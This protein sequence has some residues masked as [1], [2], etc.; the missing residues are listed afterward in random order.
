LRHRLAH[1]V[2][3]WSLAGCTALGTSSEGSNGGRHPWTRPHVLRVGSQTSPT[4]LNPLL[5]G[6]TTESAIGRLMFDVLV[7]ID[8]SGKREVPELAQTV[9]TLENGGI[10]RDG[11]TLTYHLRKGVR[12]QDGVPLTS[13]DVKFSWG[14][15]LNPR[16]NV[17]EQ[18]GYSLVKSVDTPDDTTVVFHMKQP[19]APAVDT[20]FAESDSPYA[21]VPAHILAKYPDINSIPFNSA[22]VGS[23]PY[24]FK[25]WVR[26]DH[27]TLVRNDDYFLGK[28]KLDEIVVKFVPDENTELNELRTHDIDWQFEASEEEYRQLRALPDTRLILQAKDE[29]SRL[30]MNGRHPPLDD[31]RVRRAI[32]YAVDNRKLTDDLTFGSAEPADED[33]PPFMWAHTENVTHYR[34]DPGRAEALLA[35]AGWRLGSDGYVAKDGRRLALDLV[36]NASNATRRTALVEIQAM[37]RK[38]GIEGDVKT[39]QGGL[40]FATMGQGG[41]LQNGKFDLSFEAWVA[42]IDPDQSS[43]FL[44]ADQPPHG[45]NVSHYCNPELDAAEET[46]L[47]RFDRPTRKRAYDRIEAILTRDVPVL[48]IWWPRQIQALNPDF[49]NF[50]PNPVTETWNAYTWDI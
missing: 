42:G 36:T 37:L 29:Y 21:V 45:S 9:P 6:D 28:P 41:I 10:S 38:I 47:T 26:G 13:R 49:K 27:L 14:A 7:T 4:T 35:A 8:E 25:E 2:A 22:P 16:N 23:G 40:L 24:K 1:L 12:W 19:F 30:E 5:A 15:I 32:A 3:C 11:L 39:Y 48:A 34:P 18:T 44:C 31:V 46:A 33:L 50:K 43:L 20:L 17:L